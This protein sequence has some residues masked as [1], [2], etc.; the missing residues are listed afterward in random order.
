MRTSNVLQA[1]F[2]SPQKNNSYNILLLLLRSYDHRCRCLLEV[3][4]FSLKSCDTLIR[5]LSKRLIRHDSYNI[6]KKKVNG[7]IVD[8]ADCTCWSTCAIIGGR[9]NVYS[10]VGLGNTDK[11]L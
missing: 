8:I 7:D 5:L 1:S 9:R 10:L 6:I 11:A 4:F 3:V 2:S